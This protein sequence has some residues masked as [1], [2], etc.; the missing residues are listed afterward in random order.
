[1]SGKK[2]TRLVIDYRNLNDKTIDDRYPLPN[3]EDILD[4]LGRCQ[5]FTTLDL[6]SGYH[7]IQMQPESV[8]KTAFNTEDGHFEFTRMPFGLKNAPATF[9]RIMDDVLRGLV[10]TFCLVYLDDIIIFSPSLKEHI[11]HLKLVFNRLQQ[12]NLKLQLDKC[13]FLRKETEFLG[14][15]ITPEGIKPNKQKIDIIKKFELPK[16]A[17]DIKSFLGLIGYYRKFIENFAKITKPLTKCL[18]KNA[19][20]IHNDEFITTFEKCKNLLCNDPILKYPDFNEPFELTTDASNYALGAVLSQN[21]HAIAYASRTLND[22]ETRYATIEKE[23]LAIIWACKHFR[24]YLY[25]N[26]FT[27]YTDHKPLSWLFSLKEHNSRVMRWRLKLEEYNYDIKYTKG[28]SNQADFLSRIRVENY[29][30]DLENQSTCAENNNPN[31][32]DDFN[33]FHEQDD[34]NTIHTNQGNIDNEIPFTEKVLNSAERQIILDS[35]KNITQP[36]ITHSKV[37]NKHRYFINIPNQIKEQKLQD[38]LKNYLLPN[39]KNTMFFKNKSLEKMIILEI[40][41]I[42]N[43]KIKVEITSKF[44]TD[45]ENK[46]EQLQKIKYQHEGKASHRGINE[47][48]LALKRKYYFPNLDKTVSE[49]VNNCETCNLAKYDRKPQKMPLQLTYTPRVPFEIIHLDLLFIAHK[50]VLTIIDAF[51]KYAQAYIIPD[52]NSQTILNYI[53]KYMSHHGIPHKIITDSGPEFQN[54]LFN[55]FCELHAIVKHTTSVENSQSNGCVERFHSTLLEGLRNIKIEK[56]G[57]SL[58]SNLI[59]VLLGYNNCRHSTTKFTPFEVIH[60]QSNIYL[61][62][63][64]NENKILEDFI[65]NRAENIKLIN[66]TVHN[67]IKSHKLKT[68]NKINKNRIQP[69]DIDDNEVVF[70]KR[71]DRRQKLRS[72]FHKETV[73]SKNKTTFQIR[74][75]NHTTK[76]KRDTIKKRKKFTKRKFVVADNEGPATTVNL[77]NPNSETSP[78]L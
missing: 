11:N 47:V 32:I 28:S 73:N 1:M 8:E 63:D 49:Y 74:R 24:P 42:F 35:S 70:V 45:I 4:K 76:L 13:H 64:V 14:H 71:K 43:R 29:I 16:T 65:Q 78:K 17:K 15:V 67:K 40:Q 75:K 2:K 50:T 48:T 62:Q 44:V 39:I 22:A 55:Q 60:G 19:K 9:Q 27:I 66:N 54:K 41:K 58:E 37:F 31:Q 59:T 10:N 34:S 5:Y 6:A 12:H 77:H 51:S 72:R 53:T 38:L 25:G 69:E 20:I 30:N 33:E 46:E 23:M 7:Q 56:P 57:A 52:K 26:R 18:K 21:G 61:P 68:C 3:I 36:V